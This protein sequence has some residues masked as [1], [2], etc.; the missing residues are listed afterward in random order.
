M[1]HQA[2]RR[3]TVFTV[4][5]FLFASLPLAA[6]G[7]RSPA[8]HLGYELGDR[9]TPHARVVD[10]CRELAEHSDRVTMKRYGE[11]NEGREL[12]LL[13]ISTPENLERLD[14]L[15][16]SMTKLADPR[17]LGPEETAESIIAEQPVFVW[18]SYNV[19]GN[20]TSCTEAA[21]KTMYDLAST[22][23]EPGLELLRRSVVI[24]DPCINPDGRDRYVNWFNSVVGK[25]G[26]P[27][28]QS[29]EHDEPWPGGR[30]NHYYF[31]LNRDW[32]FMT[33]VETRAR[34][35]EYIKW[36]PQVH[37]DFHEMGRESS[38]FFFPADRPV[39]DNF[40]PYTTKWGERFGRG[41]AAAFDAMGWDY[42][43]AES[44]DLFYPGYGDSWPSL[45]GAIG[46][47]YEQAGGSSAGV[48]VK[49]RD[50]SDLSLRDR[51][52]HHHATSMAT[53]RTAVEGRTEL[54]G[55]FHEFRRSAIEEGKGGS[56][57]EFI[58]VPGDDH[59]R[60]GRLIE[61]LMAQGI[62]VR[63]ATSG[64]GAR[65]VSDYLGRRHEEKNFQ[66]G[67][68][69]VSLAQPT[70]RLI[71]TLLEPKTKIK[72]L[73]FYDVSAWSLPLAFG[74]EAFW[75]GQPTSS[76]SVPVG[77]V[78][79]P[80]GGLDEGTAGF[81]YLL[82]WDTM[83]SV[84][85]AIRMLER[86]LVVKSA[87]EGFTLDERAWKAGTLFVPNGRNPDDLPRQLGE[88][89]EATGVRF[90]PARTGMTEKGID[91]GSD[92]VV[93]LRR[94]KIALI[95]GE[96][97][98]STSFGAT[99]FVIEELYGIPHSCFSADSIAGL[100]LEDYSAVVIP[101]GFTRFGAEVKT[102]L[103]RFAREGGVVVAMSGAARLLSKEGNKLSEISTAGLEK[104]DEK[105]EAAKKK[106]RTIKERDA[107]RRRRSTPGSIF[108][109]DLDPDH[110]LS[111]GYDN[112]IAAFQRGMLS[113]DPEGG[114]VPVARFVD[115][116]PL[117][118]YILEESE[119]KLRGRGYAMVERK[120]RGTI[121]LI[122][123]DPNFRS[124]WHG[125]SRLFLNAVLLLPRH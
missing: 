114:G 2:L 30:S 101:S 20:E 36:T 47:T 112:E 100:K 102:R 118:G 7:L 79:R 92:K 73:Y 124:V 96:G 23:D 104:P 10:Y 90:V 35:A 58:L 3:F 93:R 33:Q 13:F 63:R 116:P 72:E 68:Y 89:A 6:Q 97:I 76:E 85:A 111:F 123:G 95:G 67:V 43:T 119:K 5:L 15:R 26:D 56:V 106:P 125:L 31:D 28:P 59:E 105:K 122:A 25:I 60:A 91:L 14:E 11:T 50:E 61:L 74:V 41:N 121:V 120:G 48:V 24:L 46:M 88:I 4:T 54:L 81:G 64:F 45:H 9:Y 78:T 82:R 49:R 55:D 62:E 53:I 98:S 34:I 38:Y 44:F 16:V 51:L 65:D 29:I 117:S 40:P 19:H 18:L 71:K 37:V 22:D 66:K 115:A 83:A 27:N 99:R 113:F 110:P 84:R 70:K 103:E 32:A 109:V 42:Y 17:R 12:V 52:D 21:L 94:P 87:R 86:G 8:E 77:E 80:E 57:R 1:T 108:R 69:L 39:N 75:S 107:E